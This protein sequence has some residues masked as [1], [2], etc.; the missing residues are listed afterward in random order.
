MLFCRCL[1]L[2]VVRLDAV[3]CCCCYCCCLLLLLLLLFVVAVLLLLFVVADAIVVV[4]V[5]A[6]AAAVAIAV[7]V[8]VIVVVCCLLFVVHRFWLL[9]VD[10]CLL[11]WL[12]WLLLS[13]LSVLLSTSLLL[14]WLCPMSSFKPY[15]LMAD[16]Q[17]RLR[18]TYRIS[19]SVTVGLFIHTGF[20]MYAHLPFGHRNYRWVES[21]GTRFSPIPP[22]RYLD[23]VRQVL[24]IFP[25]KPGREL[26]FTETIAQDDDAQ[27]Y[28][29]T[30]TRRSTTDWLPS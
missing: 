11:L 26:Y 22:Q 18:C 25:A 6:A 4:V 14:S 2:L 16:L 8:I 3:A 20:W 15:K 7:V 27:F 12:L 28:A 29:I 13:L 1:L 5:V 10:C 23:E 30:R 21:K 17:V 19:E 24:S 9:L